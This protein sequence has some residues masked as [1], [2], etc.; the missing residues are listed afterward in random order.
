MTSDRA[1]SA[2]AA[3][4]LGDNTDTVKPYANQGGWMQSIREFLDRA[5][6]EE[7][8]PPDDITAFDDAISQP[9]IEASQGSSLIG[10]LRGPIRL[11]TLTALR[12]LAVI[13]QTAAILAV[14]FGLGFEVP[15]G[16]CLTIIAASA[17]LNIFTIL[18]F[19]PQRFLSDRETALY[20]AFDIV[21]L[22]ALLFCTGGLQNPF[23]VLILAPVTIAASVL[24]LRLTSFVGGLALLNLGLI[25]LVHMPLPWTVY[26]DFSIPKVYV[27]GVWTAL[28]FSVIFFA[29]YAHRIAQ[30]ATR[31][32]SALTATQM[33]LTREERLSALGGL[34]AAAA[35]ELGTPLATIQ[36]TAQ[37]MAEDLDRPS[38]ELNLKNLRDDARLLTSQ[39]HRC[40]DILGRLS[41]RGD[42]G[43]VMH[44]QIR[45]DHALKE[46]ASPFLDNP[47]G[48]EITFLVSA[49][50]S[51]NTSCQ[52]PALAR[53]PEFIY[54]LR[55][56]IENAAAFAAE[57]VEIEVT[58]SPDVIRVAVR[59]DGPGFTPDI[60]AR[61]GEPY[62]NPK[63]G[64]P[65]NRGKSG[66]G[67]GFFIAKTLLEHTGGTVSFG[68]VTSEKISTPD[69]AEVVVEW[70]P[71][72]LLIVG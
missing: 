28:S 2:P 44:D 9:L 33:V 19:S 7:T 66:M 5:D 38:D 11:R 8:A 70:S 36:V 6:T 41:R 57:N 32:H 22:C 40:R 45:L 67:L 37:E 52:P 18:R 4:E 3:D 27:I 20:I 62:I 51:A 69:G 50:D 56:V 26:G 29:T 15:L 12:W 46:A 54:G 1:S 10:P 58:S 35:H 23:S 39:A 31:M 61:L 34:A 16:L 48:P 21:Q 60:L 25:A 68:N 65:R 43:D 42:E 71:E 30:E 17:W 59:D 24:P 63:P 72:K 53:R 13:G 55:N 49:T 64:P 47:D 14:H